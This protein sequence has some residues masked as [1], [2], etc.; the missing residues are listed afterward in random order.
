MSVKDWNEDF[1]GW[2]WNINEENAV[3]Y[4]PEFIR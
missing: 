2:K 1:N 3:K 4:S